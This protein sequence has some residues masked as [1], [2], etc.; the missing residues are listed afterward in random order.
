VA[1]FCDSLDPD[2]FHR[3]LVTKRVVPAAS[4]PR[5]PSRPT[6][7][8]KLGESRSS[9]RGGADRRLAGPWDR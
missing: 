9:G 1:S 6:L 2:F 8:I 3:E 4:P 7:T 5:P